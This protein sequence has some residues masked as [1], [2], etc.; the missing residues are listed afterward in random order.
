MKIS[1]C[2]ALVFSA[3]LLVTASAA[4]AELGYSA[5]LDGGQAGTPS[6]G[7]GY[8]SVI[9]SNDETLITLHMEFSGLLATETASHIH[10]P[11]APGIN[12]GVQIPLPLGTPV[13]GQFPITPTQVT[14]LKAGLLYINVHTTLYAGGEIRGQISSDPTPAENT[15]WGRIKALY[16]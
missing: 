2:V 1:Q 12:A 9:L 11:A 6:P 14:Y 7:V 10:G 4:R 15:T 8:A 3:L 5:H 13:D 16:R